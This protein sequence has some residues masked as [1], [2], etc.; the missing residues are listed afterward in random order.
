VCSSDLT[1]LNT[2]MPPISFGGICV[3]SS[4]CGCDGFVDKAADGRPTPNVIVADY[5][6]LPT[7]GLRPDQLMAIGQPQRDEIEHNVSGI[8]AKDL[9]ERLP[10]SPRDFDEFI[11]RGHALASKMS[12]DVVA[13]DYVI[14]GI[15]RASRAQRLKQIA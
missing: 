12:W 13:R 7:K 3:F 14:P 4:V 2:Q 8:V 1:L 11:D 9:V 6:D 10:R 5:T 15:K